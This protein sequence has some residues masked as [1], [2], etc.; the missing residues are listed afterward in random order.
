MSAS[1]EFHDR[2]L[3]LGLARVSE[4]AAMASAQLVGRG[5]EMAAD[6]A[7]VN[8][9]RDQLNMLEI[10]GVVVIGEG[11]RDEAPRLFMGEKVGT[12]SGP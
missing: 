11:E 5:D 10:Q 12:G 2:A 6:Q 1:V 8:A 9:M 4:A 7:A 3:S